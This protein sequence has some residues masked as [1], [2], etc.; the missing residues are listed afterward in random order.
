MRKMTLANYFFKS[1]I[2]VAIFSII[3]RIYFNYEMYFTRY[4]IPNI[5]LIISLIIAFKIKK[6]SNIGF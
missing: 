6:Y 4:L 2:L 3:F 1:D 5:F